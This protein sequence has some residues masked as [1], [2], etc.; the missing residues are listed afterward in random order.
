MAGHVHTHT[1]LW[2]TARHCSITKGYVQEIRN[3]S[4]YE[5]P[6]P[7]LHKPLC[8]HWHSSRKKLQHEAVAHHG[9]ITSVNTVIRSKYPIMTLLSPSWF[10]CGFSVT[11]I[12]IVCLMMIPSKCKR[13]SSDNYVL[14]STLLYVSPK[15][16][17][18][19]S[20]LSRWAILRQRRNLIGGKKSADLSTEFAEINDVKFPVVLRF[21]SSI[22]C[23]YVV[24][25]LPN[26]PR[27]R[28]PN[29]WSAFEFS[30]QN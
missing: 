28:R 11:R 15:Q 7:S 3:H 13:A 12:W 18:T 20:S 21:F 5:W 23:S 19:D 1:V 14:C 4:N 2:K 9:Q 26:F 10:W 27:S 6:D 30:F 16:G 17:N 24:R 29:D 8:M 22:S 25:P